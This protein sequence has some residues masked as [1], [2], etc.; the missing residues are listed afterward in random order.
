MPTTTTTTVTEERSR[1]TLEV[2]TP[3]ECVVCKRGFD[4]ASGETA[5]VLRHV[6]YYYDFVHA[7]SC[8]RAALDWIFVE[9][10]YDVAEFGPDRER[11]RVLRAEP[12]ETAPRETGPEP[13]RY[14]ALVEHA[15]GSCW[16]EVIVRQV[17][18]EAEPGGAEFPEERSS[19]CTPVDYSSREQS[20]DVA[21][22][23]VAA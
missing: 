16:L 8:L 14:W 6:A 23:T 20:N 13:L 1:R 4:F 12:V 7:G 9:P 18:W 2:A 22:R 3:L 19:V 15:D 17:G 11:L 5:V 10:G 21:R